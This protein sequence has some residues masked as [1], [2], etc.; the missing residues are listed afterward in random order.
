MIGKPINY[1]R[2]ILSC[3]SKVSSL[4]CPTPLPYSN[5]L[6]LVFKP[7]GVSLDNE[8]CETKSI[9]IITSASFKNIQ[10]FKT[11]TGDWKFMEDMTKAEKKLCF[12]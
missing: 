12:T 10:Y 3:M 11:E 2:Y 4:L 9:P 7:F 8:I 6:T 5:V 1:S